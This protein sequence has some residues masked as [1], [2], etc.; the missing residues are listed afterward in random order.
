MTRFENVYA[1]SRRERGI[2]ASSRAEH[3]LGECRATLADGGQRAVVGNEL[4]TA[5]CRVRELQRGARGGGEHKTKGKESGTKTRRERR[6]A[7]F[8]EWMDPQREAGS[9]GEGN[10]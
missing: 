4:K 7:L 9:K 1:T 3:G 8:A 5:N 10:R 6:R 2:V